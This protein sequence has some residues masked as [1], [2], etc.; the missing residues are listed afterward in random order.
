[1]SRSIHTLRRAFFGA[2]VLGSLGFGAAQAL[3]APRA[4]GTAPICVFAECAARC[5]LRG[6]D[7]GTCLTTRDCVCYRL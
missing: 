7:G 2:A 4:Q 5:I 1:M 3:A 6:Y